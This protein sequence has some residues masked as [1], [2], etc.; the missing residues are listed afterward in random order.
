MIRLAKETRG[1]FAAVQRFQ[2]SEPVHL[3]ERDGRHYWQF[4]DDVYWESEGL[5]GAAVLALV[6]ERRIKVQRRVDRAMDAGRRSAS[7]AQVPKRLGIPD[8]AKKAVWVRDGGRCVQCGSSVNLQFDH[9]IPLAM[10]G[11]SDE[12]NLQLLCSDCNRQKG[13]SLTVD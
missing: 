12:A 11:G 1:E 5:D 4:Q 6:L 3:A 13:S 9:V 2:S 10:G 8:D 7:G